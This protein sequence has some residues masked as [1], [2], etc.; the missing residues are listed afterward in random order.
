MPGDGQSIQSI[1]AAAVVRY[2][3]RLLRTRDERPC[4]RRTNN[5]LNEI[6]P[7]HCAASRAQHQASIDGKL[8]HGLASDKMALRCAARG[9]RGR[10]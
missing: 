8:E 5:S 6:A 10:P 1:R 4:S 3:H 9:E 2:R 7:S